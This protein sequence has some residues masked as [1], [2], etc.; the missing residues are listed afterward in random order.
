MARR[1]RVGYHFF[2]EH[3]S[4]TE[5]RLVA[6]YADMWSTFGPPESWTAKN[7]VLDEWCN[8]VGRSPADTERTVF[9][10]DSEIPNVDQC[11][12]AGAQHIVVGGP[13]PFD[14]G[15][16]RTLLAAADR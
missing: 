11:V 9:I 8:R 3:T 16:L 2:Q 10:R 7:K 5:L 4:V 6:Q 12:D 15:P 14:L 1:F 13:A